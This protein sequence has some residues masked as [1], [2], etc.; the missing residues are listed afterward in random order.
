M[1]KLKYLIVG[2]SGF[3]GSHLFKYIHSKGKEVHGTRNKSKDTN[4]IKFNLAEDNFLE[5][6]NSIYKKNLKNLV[7]II[8][9]KYGLMDQYVKDKKQS[10][11]LEV[12]KIKELIDT[13]NKLN[14]KI[15]YLS[16]SYIFDGE[17]GNYLE[18]SVTNP[19]S[20]YGKQKLHIDNYITN[21]L[22]NFLILRLD[23]IVGDNPEENHL[24]TEWLT[25]LKKN[26]P[27]ICIKNQL[28]SPTLIDD[29]IKGIF[30]ACEMELIGV[31]HHANPKKYNRADLAKVF[32]K[33]MNKDVIIQEK[34][35]NEFGML[36]KRPKDSSLNVYKFCKSTGINYTSMT[37]AIK[38]FK[39][40]LVFK[41]LTK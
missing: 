10:Y 29:I 27:I 1:L 6:L 30:L 16:T 37:K 17:T 4:F 41:G 18:G 21:N 2:A 12:L 14:I 40:N 7:V 3:V 32:I 34:N 13:A 38:N 31:F 26:E 19:I 11:N 23:K 9:Y 15:V 36:E 25:C 24:F 33:M 5:L 39:D 35:L 22:K 8:C 20:E 28:L